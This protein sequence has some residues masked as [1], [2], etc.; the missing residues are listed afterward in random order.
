MTGRPYTLQNRRGM[1]HGIRSTIYLRLFYQI[2][3]SQ[4]ALR[5]FKQT[6]SDDS[7]T[8]ETCADRVR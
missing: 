6:G 7:G 1:K 2:C 8:K 3:Q 5:R 4:Y